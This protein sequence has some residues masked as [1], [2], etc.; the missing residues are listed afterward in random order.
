MFAIVL[1]PR[2]TCLLRQTASR[3]SMRIDWRLPAVG[4]EIHYRVVLIMLGRLMQAD[5]RCHLTALV[6]SISQ[7]IEV[8]LDPLQTSLLC[9]R[10]ARVSSI[11]SR[12]GTTVRPFHET[13]SLHSPL[14]RCERLSKIFRNYRELTKVEHSKSF[15]NE[16][17][18]QAGAIVATE[19]PAITR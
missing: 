18:T 13:N 14:D 11:V 15:R 4:R 7:G 10:H 17:R 8:R 12:R 2:M 6:P 19:F 5:S 3:I 9:H 16:N 1:V